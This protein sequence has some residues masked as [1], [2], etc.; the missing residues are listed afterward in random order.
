[1]NEIKA[2]QMIGTQRS[3][4]NLLR[5]LLNQYPEVAAPHPPHILQ[6]FLP[7][8][9]GYGDL[10][11]KQNMVQLVD[12]VCKLVEVNPVPWTGVNPNRNQILAD[13]RIP[14]LTEIFRLIYEEAAISKGAS[15]WM[16]KSMANVH[17]ADM[18]EKNGIRPV[19]LYLY[20]DGR[21]VACSFKKAIVGEKHIYFIAQQWK[22]DQEA[23]LALKSNTEPRRFVEV[24]Y[25]TL[26]QNPEAE[27]KRL[28]EL[29]QL[30][31]NPDVFNYYQS[32]ESR[33]T[34]TAGK[35]WE[36]VARPIFSNSK[37]FMNELSREEIVIFEAVAGDTLRK[38]GYEPEFAEESQKRTFNSSELEEFSKENKRM[39]QEAAL[40]ADPEG[41]K[42]RQPQDDL[43][44]SIKNRKA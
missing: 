9:P 26:L 13:C 15:Q 42:L 19:Y 23:C 22:E 36:N 41:M 8:L 11:V 33:N 7:L 21:D 4:S 43:I 28:S 34:S 20:R 6:R 12:D 17:Y 2:I 35:M 18:M 3:G 10:T 38:L 5:L 16:C 32:E 44:Q 31:Y 24:R 25:E 1:M 37:K 29:L 39:K 14:H 30:T 40:K 27:M